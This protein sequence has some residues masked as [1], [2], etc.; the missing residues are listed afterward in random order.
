MSFDSAVVRIWHIHLSQVSM[1][2]AWENVGMC[3]LFAFPLAHFLAVFLGGKKSTRKF[4][5]FPGLIT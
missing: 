5:G 2:D 4:S 1:N 3:A